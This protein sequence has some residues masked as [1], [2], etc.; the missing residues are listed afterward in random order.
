MA[1][2]EQTAGPPYGRANHRL[3]RRIWY[4]ESSETNATGR[5]FSAAA[6]S[7]SQMCS[8]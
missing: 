3:N 2:N 5:G 6:R 8:G 7:N 4:A 1:A